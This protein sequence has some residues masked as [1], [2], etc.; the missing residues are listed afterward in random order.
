[1]PELK[2]NGPYSSGA[3]AIIGWFAAWAMHGIRL[4]G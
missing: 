4:H 2:A 3:A 1:V